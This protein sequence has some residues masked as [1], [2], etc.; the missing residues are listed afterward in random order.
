MTAVLGAAVLAALAVLLVFPGSASHARNGSPMPARAALAGG[1]AAVLFTSWAWLDLHHVLLLAVGSV[2]AMGGVRVVARRRAA[3]HAAARSEQVLAACDAIAADL[4]AGQPPS[5]ALDRAA[6]A[7]PELAPVA[8]TGHLGA[9]V[10]TA[11]REVAR[12][13]GGGKLRRAAATW[14]VAHE[15]GAGLADAMHAAAQAIREELQTSRLVATEL[16]AAH[17]T[18]RML[19]VLPAGV[20][21]LGIGVGGDPVGF[22]LDSTPGVVVLAAG[23]ALSFAGL[24]WLERIADGVVR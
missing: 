21:L 4:R 5:S 19:A 16:A 14:Q 2:T 3:V 15:T 12:R 24:L 8:A 13:P 1:G 10:P 17:A 23:L 11:M 22:L 9:D 20:L 6:R 18:A 7:W